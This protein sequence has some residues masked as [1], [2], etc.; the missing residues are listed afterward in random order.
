MA[1]RA[2]RVDANQPEL[3]KKLRE[4]GA[5]VHC[6]HMV[7]D[8]FPDL[9]VGWEGANILLEVKD[10]EKCASARKLTPDEERFRKAWKGDVH[11]VTCFM[12]CLAALAGGA[13]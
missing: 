8:G 5:S 7:G 12:D 11:T 4:L 13:G 6:T 2:F 10:S 3:V 1:R 9:V